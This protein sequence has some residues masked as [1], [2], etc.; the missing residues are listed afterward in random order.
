MIT[1][2]L[3]VVVI[4]GIGR[5]VPTFLYEA[6]REPGDPIRGEVQ[7]EDAHAAAAA[8]V[9]RGYHVLQILDTDS[10]GKRGLDGRWM[11][12][13][14]KGLLRFTRSLAM[15]LRAGLPLVLALDKLRLETPDKTWRSIIS[16]IKARIEDGSTFSEA[17]APPRVFN[18]MYVNLAR[19]GEESGKLVEYLQRL[20]DLGERR[21]ELRN[22]IVMAMVYPSVMLGL[23][24]ITVLILVTFVVP[25]FVGVFKEAGQE[26]PMPT[27]VL[28]GLSSFLSHWWP[29]VF[30]T[31][32]AIVFAVTQYARTAQGKSLLDGALLKIPLLQR[33]VRKGQIAAFTRTLAT[34][35]D[36]G[37]GAVPAL[38][39]TA[40]TLE[41]EHFRHAVKKM[42][43]DVRGGASLS[44]SSE[45]SALFPSLVTSAM[46]LGEQSGDLAGVLT[47]VAEENEREL[48]REV[49]VVMTLMEPLMIVL[50]GSVVGFIVM[51][52][53]LPI[54][55]LGDT[56]PI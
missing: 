10:G 5:I 43:E 22:R 14:R 23:G 56:L 20:A 29:A 31:S 8:L 38:D 16:S 54:F 53:I 36:S 40:A 55:Q 6:L 13:R 28:V 7:A 48:D 26:L 50:I 34:L 3:S 18:P 15:L 27:Q 1:S 25:M 42:G 12:G 41:N 47:E 11:W 35:L 19:A 24:T 21:A 4:E 32:A 33:L 30:G 45:K 49:K 51:A 52:M 46:S 17:L 39:A 44:A 2:G 9:G 37:I